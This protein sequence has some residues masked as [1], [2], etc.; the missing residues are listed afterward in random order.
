MTVPKIVDVF[1]YL[2]TTAL[3][4]TVATWL[5]DITKMNL[6][7]YFDVVTHKGFLNKD[8][9]NRCKLPPENKRW[10]WKKEKKQCLKSDKAKAALLYH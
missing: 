3:K 7:Y 5:A 9:E 10:L 8:L 6:S 2:P 1:A 4:Y